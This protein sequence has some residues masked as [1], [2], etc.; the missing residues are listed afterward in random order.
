MRLCAFAER[1][2]VGIARPHR[3]V[4]DDAPIDRKSC[5]L[6]ESGIRTDAHGHDDEIGRK[7]GPVF[8]LDSANLLIAHGWL[9]YSLW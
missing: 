6:G 5:F 9:W 4:H 2:D 7:L 8:K 3:L 1:E